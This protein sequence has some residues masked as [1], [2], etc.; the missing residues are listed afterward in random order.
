MIE[1]TTESKNTPAPRKLDDVIAF[2]DA[3]DVTFFSKIVNAS[4]KHFNAKAKCCDVPTTE[5]LR[6]AISLIE[7]I[8]TD[9]VVI[10]ES[11]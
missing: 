10:E 4:L 9:Q 5:A 1:N 2:N 6:R 7:A 3:V 8:C 11:R